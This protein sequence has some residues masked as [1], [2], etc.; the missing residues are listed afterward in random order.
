MLFVDE[1]ERI[2]RYAVRFVG[3]ET[4]NDWIS[5]AIKSAVMAGEGK[6]K[7]LILTDREIERLKAHGFDVQAQDDSPFN[8]FYTIHLP[9]KIKKAAEESLQTASLNAS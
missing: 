7:D 9:V 1:A 8:L 2:R 6:V 4:T 5:V 3:R